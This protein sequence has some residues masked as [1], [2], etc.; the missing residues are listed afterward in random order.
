[1]PTS[2]DAQRYR[3]IYSYYRP[4]PRNETLQSAVVDNTVIQGLDWKQSVRA[5]SITNFDLTM[6]ATGQ[7]VDG[8]PSVAWADGDRVLLKDQSDPAENGIYYYDIGTDSL[9][10]ALDAV[11]DTL[12]CGAAV[13]IEAGGT[14][15]QG[16]FVLTTQD[17][18]NVGTDAQT[19]VKFAGP[20]S[21]IFISKTV[22]TNLAKT[23]Y[24]VSFDTNLRYTDA[25]GSDVFFF[26]SGSVGSS[27]G[28]S[29]FGGDVVVSGSVRTLFGLSGSLTQLADGRS[30]LVAGT[31][32]TI[33][34]ASSGQITISSTGGGGGG[35]SYFSSTT[36]GSIFTTGSS[37]FV[38]ADVGVDSPADKGTDVFFYVSGS[39]GTNRSLFG[40]D[41]VASGSVD[42]KNGLFVTGS[43]DIMGDIVKVTGSFN[44]S[45]T[46]TATGNIIS[47]GSVYAKTG[48]SGSLTKLTDGKSYLVAGTNVTITSGSTGQVTISSTG[49]GTPGGSTTQIQFN[50]GGSFGGSA[51]LTYDS[52][53]NV[54]GA[55]VV[56]ASSGFSGS[57][58]ALKD[59]SAYLR[60]GT[61]SVA[62]QTG[63]ISVVTGTNGAVTVNSYVF[64]SDLTVSLTGGRTFGRYASGAT[65][66]ATGK[67]PAEVILLAIA[68]PINPTV[69]LSSLTSIA[70]NQT[71][72]SNS[73]SFGYIINSLG[74][75]VSTCLLEWRR[76]NS[77]S[78]TTLSTS[79]SITSYTHSLTDTNY[80]TQPFNYRYTVTDTLGAS[81]TATLNI[82][83]ASYVA[84][85]MSLSVVTTSPGSVTGETN[86][87]RERGNVG[88]TISGT[89]TRNSAY[90]N[91]TSYS[92]QYQVN[93]SGS[94]TD[95]P[96]LS[97]V[98]ISA[99]STLVSIPSTSHNNAG[100]V[101]STSLVYRVQVVDSYTTSNSSSTTVSFLYVIFY[102]P[103]AAAPTNSSGVRSL[104]NKVFTDS[105]NPF[106]LNTGTTYKDFSVA[107]P[108]TISV[109]SVVDL[110]ALNADI[111][112]NYVLSTF[113]VNDS[114]G[115]AVSY[116]VYTL[117]NAVPYSSSHR[118]QI[119]RA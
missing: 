107:M 87:K 49:G 18:I 3:K 42:V 119:T 29:A 61:S 71:A 38:G 82:T 56:T 21:T 11:N 108:A 37:A 35:D 2:R 47:T 12:T 26:V 70:F 118:H 60:V 96:G 98:S 51:G 80:N 16:A 79:T 106:N 36:A 105:S 109:T 113:N 95:V 59:G 101:T 24:S 91:M 4:Q 99:G 103:A 28:K 6:A 31:N 84:P 33:T 81:A 17:P 85:S 27:E 68:E 111:T 69:S 23:E 44:M 64:P 73:L 32:V 75:S 112:A 74:A 54:L 41:V 48:F 46:L 83:P 9:I 50:D 55:T 104:T 10:R 90:V 116:H 77:G 88:S 58:T 66:P 65:I 8:Y 92:V 94:W 62:S 53:T 100:L 40:G 19:W 76:N 63:S 30:Y 86:T 97:N 89:I 43:L 67:T 13:Y 114:A 25:I 39:T 34:S 110:D 115:T 45:G 14:N 117:S 93:G 72:I 78:W 1:M 5:A 52:A 57:L 15:A 22:P 102:A 20:G 7:S